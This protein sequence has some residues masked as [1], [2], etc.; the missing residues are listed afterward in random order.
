MKFSCNGQVR[1]MA[2]ATPRRDETVALSIAVADT[3]PGITPEVAAKLFRPFAQADSTSTRRYGGTGLG[4]AI[5]KQLVELMGGAIE[6]E[7]QFGEGSVFRFTILLDTG[8]SAAVAPALRH[9]CLQ[10]G[11]IGIMFGWPR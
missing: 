7:S 9:G 11:P 10:S 4:L 3:G 8:D 2:R 5:S 1:I 6:V